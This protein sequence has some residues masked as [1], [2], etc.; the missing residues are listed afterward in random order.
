MIRLRSGCELWEI[1]AILALYQILGA[2]LK[3]LMIKGSAV[4]TMNNNEPIRNC[5]KGQSFVQAAMPPGVMQWIK[6]ILPN[7]DRIAQFHVSLLGTQFLI[8]ILWYQ[9]P[10]K[11]SMLCRLC[12]LSD[13]L[14]FI[15]NNTTAQS[16]LYTP[17]FFSF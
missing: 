8:Y 11:R 13:D 17:I 6:E 12:R 9:N 16:V 3:S 10:S 7:D 2:V 15:I 5:A 4:K 14:S 1:L